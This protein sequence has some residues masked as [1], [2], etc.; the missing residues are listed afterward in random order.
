MTDF[1]N[2]LVAYDSSGFANRAFKN[3]LDIAEPK[4]KI[5]VITVVTGMYQPSIGFSMKYNEDTLTKYTAILKK[6]FSSLKILANKKNINISFKILY[7][8]SV[9]KAIVTY[10]NS[11]KFDLIVIGSHGR[12]GINKIVLGSVANDVAHKANIPVMVV[13]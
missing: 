5:V 11:H 12:T 6:T 2:I 7:N 8:P 13:K 10:V 4:S 9:S 1:K 3:A